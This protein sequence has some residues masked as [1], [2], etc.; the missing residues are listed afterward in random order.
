MFRPECS[1]NADQ[2]A[3]SV[4]RVEKRPTHNQHQSP[5]ATGKKVV[6]TGGDNT[7]DFFSL[8]PMKRCVFRV[9]ASHHANNHHRTLFL[10]E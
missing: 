8:A 10:D 5:A 3:P 9:S 6:A 7:P 1:D 4:L 2:S